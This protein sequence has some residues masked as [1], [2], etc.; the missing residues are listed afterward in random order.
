ML[1]LGQRVDFLGLLDSPVS[2]ELTDEW[3]NDI[4]LFVNLFKRDVPQLP[5]LHQTIVHLEEDEQLKRLVEQAKQVGELPADFPLNQAKRM[6]AV[7]RGHL[8]A[9]GQYQPQPYPGKAVLLQACEGVAAKGIDPRLGWSEIIK[10]NRELH[11]IPGDHMTMVVD[12]NVKVL[13]ER[14]EQCIAQSMSTP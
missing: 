8:V 13:A 1:R 7:F 6:L 11:W 9:A 4:Q 10:G 14:L 3:H 12:P 2:F 5:E